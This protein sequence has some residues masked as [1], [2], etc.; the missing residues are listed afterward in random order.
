[1]VRCGFEARALLIAAAGA[2]ALAFAAQA[3]AQDANAAQSPRGLPDAPAP[4]KRAASP[5][6]QESYVRPQGP[7]PYTPLAESEELH[8]YLYEAFG[9]YPLMVSAFV[10][11]YHQARRNPPDWREGFPGYSERFG[12]DFGISAINI[13]T[14]YALAE[15]MDEDVY[16]YRCACAG[17]WPRLKHA[18]ASVVVAGNRITG[19]PMFALPGVVAPYAGPLVA[20]RTWYPDRY[21]LKDGFRMGNY[22]LL[23]YAIGNIGLEFLPSLTHDKAKSFVR[24]FHLEN[25]HAAENV[26]AP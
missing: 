1:M 21:G 12:S 11:G 5:T 6:P 14:R 3:A 9:P 8:N 7:T 17:V 22:G 25:R 20:V 18:V 4:A 23:D 19:R 16:Y 15:A 26:D 13:S 10:A 24:R 2:L